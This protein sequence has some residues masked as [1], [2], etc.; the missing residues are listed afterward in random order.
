MIDCDVIESELKKSFVHLI[1]C[2]YISDISDEICAW[3]DLVDDYSDTE[4]T[5]ILKSKIYNLLR[6]MNEAK[7]ESED[8]YKKLV[9]RD[10]ETDVWYVV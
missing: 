6:M 3:D 9:S 8:A 1:S 10:I 5:K 4:E 2:F 7:Q